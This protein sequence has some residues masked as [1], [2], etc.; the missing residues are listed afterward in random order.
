MANR[1]SDGLTFYDLPGASDYWAKVEAEK[2]AR[3]K[4]RPGRTTTVAVVASAPSA[5]GSQ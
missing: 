1:A 2:A 3:A 4:K 5:G